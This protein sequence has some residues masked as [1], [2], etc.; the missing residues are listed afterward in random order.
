[1]NIGLTALNWIVIDIKEHTIQEVFDIRQYEFKH[2]I[3]R[4]CLHRTAYKNS[5]CNER[6]K[7]FLKEDWEKLSNE[8][9]EYYV[10]GQ[11]LKDRN[12][13]IRKNSIIRKSKKYKVLEKETNKILVVENLNKFAREHC[14]SPGTLHSTYTKNNFCR[15][16]K[17]VERL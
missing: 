2:G 1:M 12:E 13:S 6:L 16:Y 11:F 4:G 10:S 17:V 5:I 14:M 8:E 3:T 7:C 15:G 9:K